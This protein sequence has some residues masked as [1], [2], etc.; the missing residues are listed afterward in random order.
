MLFKMRLIAVNPSKK[1]FEKL[2]IR[3]IYFKNVLIQNKWFLAILLSHPE[4]SCVVII[5]KL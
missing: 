1:G 4:I 2:P 3:A 5:K